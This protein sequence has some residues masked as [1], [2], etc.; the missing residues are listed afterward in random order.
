M[1]ILESE[2]RD[3]KLS[4]PTD[5]SELKQEWFDDMLESVVVA[6][7]YIMVCLC[8]QDRLFNIINGATKSEAT[9]NVVPIAVK[10][11]ENTKTFV[12]VMD[13]IITNPSCIERANH[14]Y[15]QKNQ[16]SISKVYD[17][18]KSDNKLYN[19]I[20]KGDGSVKQIKNARPI[21]FEFKV[22]PLNDIYGV[23]GLIA[24]NVTASPFIIPKELA[25]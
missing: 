8:Y 5:F 17:Y 21:M 12:S 4:L 7:N 9:T 23:T 24:N 2:T 14:F 15:T 1:I 19:T 20:L 25:N 3:Y 10:I 13:I 6:P 22:M 16:I 11:G 18:I